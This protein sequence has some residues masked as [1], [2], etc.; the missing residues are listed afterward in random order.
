MK[1]V[2]GFF[3]VGVLG[4]FALSLTTYQGTYAQ[5]DH[6][7]A[8]EKTE[9]HA[10]VHYEP[11]TME[12]L[13]HFHGHGGPFVV[14]G[15][16]M[17][18]YAIKKYGMPKYFGITVKAEC[19]PIPPH[20]CLIDGLMVGSGATYGKKNIEHIVAEKIRVTISDDKTGASVIYTLKPATVSMLKKWE[21]DNVPVEERGEKCFTMK[22]E[23]LFEIEYTPAK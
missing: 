20:S 2:R 8:G 23:D 13:E 15:G 5:H 11:L 3:L 21:T 17:G 7:G 4:V 6:H 19:P 1:S 12:D 16:L 22:A 18:D 9:M 14:L 10:T